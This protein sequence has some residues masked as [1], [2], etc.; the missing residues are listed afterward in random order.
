MYII[1]SMRNRA[2]ALLV[3]ALT[4]AAAACRN[5][6]AK[7]YEYEEQIYLNVDGSARVIVDSSV[8]ALIA[9]RGLH[10]DPSPRA[11]LDMSQ[12]RATYEAGGCHVTRI[13]LPWYRHGRR[14]VQ[15]QL[16][17]NDVRSLAACGPLA[18]SRYVFTSDG[19][20]IRYEQRV[21]PAAG[22]DPGNVEWTGAELVAFKLHLPSKI[23]F[24]NVRNLADNSEGAPDRGNILTW[25]QR[26]TDRRAGAPVDIQVR[27]EAQSILYRTLWL[28]G[29]SFVAAVVVL[30]ALIW[31]T[32]RKGRARALQAS[33]TA[34]P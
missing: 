9:L 19:S 30:V 31:W 28:F 22:G 7:E 3:I 16:R 13:G 24:H 5:P 18:W 27:M 11:R 12:L 1:R 10:I 21:G 4:A 2:V 26:L 34:S 17:T 15:V 23:T 33:R 14:F 20:E 6:F 32:I 29:G 25:E 8:A